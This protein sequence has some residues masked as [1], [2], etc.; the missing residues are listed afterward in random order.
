MHYDLRLVIRYDF[1]RPT[2][3][4]RQ[5]LRI[6][7][8]EMPGQQSLLAHE[9]TIAPEPSERREFTDFFGTKVLEVVM[10]PGLTHCEIAMT[11]RVVRLPLGGEFDISPP[12]D[13]LAA[14]LKEVTTLG[15]TSPH[16]FLALSPRIGP[17]PVIAAFAAK[18][19]KGAETTRAA[20]AALGNSPSVAFALKRG[21]CQ[22]FAQIMIAGLRSLG[23]PA[24]YVA[25][26]LRTLPPPGK[27]RLEGADA[28]HAWVRAWAGSEVGW[29][30]HDP[31]NDCFADTDHIAVGHGRDYGDVAPVTGALRMDGGQKGSHAV[32]LIE[33]PAVRPMNGAGPVRHP[34]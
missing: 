13:R 16:H 24:A 10:A 23:I 31:T 12:L 11:A 22:D 20:V 33:V 29:I 18:A 5:L 3:A 15:P 1:D 8:A 27:P 4:G 26:F 17:D 9:T 32:D 2:G 30:D 14:E 28:M 19:A 34:Q 25:G 6:Q 21:V 7:P